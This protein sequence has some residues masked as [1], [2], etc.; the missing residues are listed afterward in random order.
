MTLFGINHFD[1]YAVIGILI[2]FGILEALGGLYS[3]GGKT[4]DDWIQE[5]VGFPLL[6]IV[7]KPA[8]VLVVLLLGSRFFGSYQGSLSHLTIWLSFPLYM[9]LD[10][11]LQYWY[12]RKAHE[13][14]WL[15][16]LHRPHHAAPTMGVLVAYRN[17]AFY[18]VLMPNIWWVGI[19]TFMGLGKIVAVGLILKQIVIIGAHSDFRWDRFMY[20]SKWLHPIAW[21]L[22]RVISTPATHFAHHGRSARDG[23]SN[24]NGNFGNMFF[25]W[26]LAFGTALIT[27]EYPEE[28]GIDNDPHDPWYVH[29]FYPFI[30]SKKEGSELSAGYAKE[31]DTSNEPITLELEA[32]KYLWCACGYSN[33]Q[34]FCDGSHN[35]T[36][37]KPVF[38]ELD[39]SKKLKLC[40]CKLTKKAPY[41]DNSHQTIHT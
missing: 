40:T 6:S 7:T 34:P 28:Y 9:L 2:L 30:K 35:G 5:V 8:I 37:F 14:E 23:I 38:F 41:C 20:N 24:P 12:H 1:A 27:R 10:D 13:W 17:A 22:E 11:L 29:L 16:K 36:K 26:D 31:K 25:L 15:W 3:R 19:M 4:K 18:Y 21:I 39:K 32:G 33:N